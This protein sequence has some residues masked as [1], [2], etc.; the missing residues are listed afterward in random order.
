M[1]EEVFILFYLI[2]GKSR[3]DVLLP[4]LSNQHSLKFIPREGLRKILK[5]HTLIKDKFNSWI[6]DIKE[7]QHST[8]HLVNNFLELEGNQY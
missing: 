2:L 7:Y 1:K 6:K 3:N 5:E 4:S 8:S